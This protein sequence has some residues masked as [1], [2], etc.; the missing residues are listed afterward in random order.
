MPPEIPV[1]SEFL[2]ADAIVSI[3]KELEDSGQPPPTYR[4]LPEG[5][6]SHDKLAD[7]IGGSAAPTRAIFAVRVDNASGRRARPSAPTGKSEWGWNG[8]TL[9]MH[10]GKMLKSEHLHTGIQAPGFGCELSAIRYGLMRPADALPQRDVSIPADYFVGGE[11]V[12]LREAAGGLSYHIVEKKRA[13][14]LRFLPAPGMTR[15]VPKIP[16]ELGALDFAERISNVWRDERGFSI[17]SIAKRQPRTKRKPEAAAAADCGALDLDLTPQAIRAADYP[18]CAELLRNA[19][20]LLRNVDECARVLSDGSPQTFALAELCAEASAPS[21]PLVA[22]AVSEQP[23]T[24]SIVDPVWLLAELKR[25]RAELED[26]RALSAR[27]QETI[28]MQEEE[29][30]AL[31]QC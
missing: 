20:E 23:T 6:P 13:S 25:T 22:D 27:Q 3:L 24:V 14:G 31:Q 26:E 12:G 30:Q 7:A 4:L 17:I 8:R 18:R 1:P 16:L 9:S 29:I 28:R 21:A 10:D 2:S 15:K 11:V 19:E 5:M